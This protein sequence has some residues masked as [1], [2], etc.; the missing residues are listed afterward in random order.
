MTNDDR[1]EYVTGVILAGG[2]STRMGTDK[3]RLKIAGVTLFGNILS[4]AQKLF[5]QVIIAGDRPDLEQPGVPSIPDRY[6][7]SALGGLYTGLLEAKHATIFVTSCDI[8]YPSEALVRLLV[9]HSHGYDV[10]VPKTP[11]GLEPLFAVYHKNCL[12]HMQAM[13][14]RK[15]YR[16]YDFYPQVR[17]NYINVE[18]QPIEWRLCLANVNTPEEFNRIK[19]RKP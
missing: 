7:G 3:A 5:P 9:D 12:A 19:E 16:I 8:P 17:T 14:E 4:L 18:D 2:K 1:Y 6:P 10:V 11:N 13:L 15:A